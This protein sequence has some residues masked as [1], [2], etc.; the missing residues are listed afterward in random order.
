VRKK[1]AV[2][3]EKTRLRWH[4]EEGDGWDGSITLPFRVVHEELRHKP[5]AFAIYESSEYQWVVLSVFN[6]R[7]T[8]RREQFLIA[9][10]HARYGGEL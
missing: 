9:M 2:L 3:P 4:R 10:C 5:E 6:C 8:L 1:K 7:H